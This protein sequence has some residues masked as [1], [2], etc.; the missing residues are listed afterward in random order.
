MF[1]ERSLA[2]SEGAKFDV[3]VSH[4]AL[5][6]VPVLDLIDGPFVVHFQGPWGDESSF[7]GARSASSKVKNFLEGRIYRRADLLIVLSKPFGDILINRFGVARDRIRIIP[8]LTQVEHF[9]QTHLTRADARKILGWPVERPIVLAMRRLVKRM[10]LDNLID[11]MSQIVARHPDV[12]LL[13]GGQGPEAEPLAHRIGR[14]GL[15]HNVQLLGFVESA[16]LP[17]AYRAADLTIVPTVALEGF[18]LVT[19]ESMAAGTPVMVTPVGGLIET[20]Q[21]LAPQLVLHGTA[22]VDLVDG[23]VGW[24]DG[25]IA[26][27]TPERCVAYAA[28]NFSWKTGLPK[29]VEVYREAMRCY[30][31]A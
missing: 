11:A 14:L 10:G 25:S 17:L 15:G 19:T 2:Q 31:G 4:F 8:G 5:Y 3:F 27:P 26:L 6:A 21:P 12:L 29:I 28:L 23:L 18:G 22:A 13:I 24:L 16:K 30:H 1:G 7:Q 9:D 20:I